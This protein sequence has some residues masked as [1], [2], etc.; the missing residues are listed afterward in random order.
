MGCTESIFT[1]ACFSYFLVYA[2]N[3]QKHNISGLA[4][5]TLVTLYVDNG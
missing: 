5:R 1:I 4:I 3:A 2:L